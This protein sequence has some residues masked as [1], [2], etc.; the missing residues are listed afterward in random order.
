LLGKAKD[1][2]GS[3]AIGPFIRLFDKAYG[4]EDLRRTHIHVEVV[5]T[6]GYLLTGESHLENISRDPLDLAGQAVNRSHQYP[7]GTMLFL[8]TQ[9]APVRD[10]HEKGKGFT[11]KLGDVVSIQA[12]RLGM[13][14][15]RVNYCDR[16]EPWSFG[17]TD[18]MQNLA[19][20]GLLRA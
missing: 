15:N 11:H 18:L 16:V 3:C 19:S 17:A 20:R 8:G 2:N 10:R 4:I 9:F 5:G 7:D 1:N 12:D 6:E 13:L 14:V